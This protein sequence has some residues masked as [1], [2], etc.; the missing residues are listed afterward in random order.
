MEAYRWLMLSALPN[1][2]E[3]ALAGWFLAVLN[4]KRAWRTGMIPIDIAWFVV[5]VQAT[6]FEPLQSTAWLRKSF[7]KRKNLLQMNISL[8]FIKFVVGL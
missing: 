4:T 7:T 1:S 8:K 6:R 3:T 2:A 5:A